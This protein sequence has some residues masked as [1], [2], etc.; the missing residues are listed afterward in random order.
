MLGKNHSI[1]MLMKAF[2]I[3][4]SFLFIGNLS[5]LNVQIDTNLS[6]VK[7]GNQL[8]MSQNLAVETFQNGDIIPEAKSNEEWKKGY[9]A[10]KPA[11]YFHNN[12][13]QQEAR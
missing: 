4:T 10:G 9:K 5:F 13:S 6:T 2:L 11:W 7:I 3:L 8:W 1:D 12:D